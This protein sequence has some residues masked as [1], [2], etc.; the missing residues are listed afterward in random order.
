MLET[1][2]TQR[3]FTESD[4]LLQQV[5][6]GEKLPLLRQPRC[7]FH[8]NDVDVDRHPPPL[9]ST[10]A[11]RYLAL[12]DRTAGLKLELRH[13]SQSTSRPPPTL[14]CSTKNLPTQSP[15]DAMHP[16]H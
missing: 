12:T 8:V 13:K 9:E 16:L 7:R 14:A 6:Y 2:T 1:F 15:L 10:A 11:A 5:I 3:R 4:F